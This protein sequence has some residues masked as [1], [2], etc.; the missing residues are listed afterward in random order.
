MEESDFVE[1]LGVP[2]LAHRLRRASDLI[3]QG[4]APYM[5]ALG[6]DAPP[7]SASTLLLLKRQGPAG[8]T[9]IARR[10]RLTHP[11]IIKMVKSLAESGY[12]SERTDPSDQRR[13]VISLTDAGQQQAR[14][15][16]A[17]LIH[18]ESCLLAVF[19]ET[20]D[21]LLGAL[22]RFESALR[23]CPLPVRLPV[24]QAS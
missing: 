20:G 10:L 5:Q 12:V 9:D 21:D 16:E 18:L 13:R 14:K 4:T 17:G 8:I 23:R 7:R 11:L 24:S 3:L 6:V 19:D 1:S 15:I 2:F 22:E